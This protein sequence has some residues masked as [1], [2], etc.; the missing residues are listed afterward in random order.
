MVNKSDAESAARLKQIHALTS[1][2]REREAF[3][4]EFAWFTETKAGRAARPMVRFF[5]KRA[6]NAK[7]RPM[8]K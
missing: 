3:I 8:A 5:S 6:I 1:N 4:E 2:L 7:R